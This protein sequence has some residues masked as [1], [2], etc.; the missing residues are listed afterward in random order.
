MF[1]S[2]KIYTIAVLLLWSL[3][4]S[5]GSWVLKFWV[6][7]SLLF[8]A[9]CLLTFD[10]F[11]NRVQK[12]RSVYLFVLVFENLFGL[13]HVCSQHEHVK[14]ESESTI[15][16]LQRHNAT[17]DSR[18]LSLYYSLPLS[19]S[20]TD[21]HTHTQSLSLT[22]SHNTYLS[23][24]H[25]QPIKIIMKYKSRPRCDENRNP[26]PNQSNKIISNQYK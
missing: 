25:T 16:T 24:S 11:L 23:L 4:N 10:I 6:Q 14:S 19:L 9:Y 1:D 5:A 22:R 17:F 3:N 2:N 20:H 26:N 12:A 8:A 18:S 15:Y 21:T 7:L 13:L